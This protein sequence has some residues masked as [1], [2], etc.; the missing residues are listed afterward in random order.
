MKEH[1]RFYDFCETVFGFLYLHFK[2]EKITALTY[3]KPQHLTLM[4]TDTS[5]T[6]CTELREYLNLKRKNFTVTIYFEGATDFQKVVWNCLKTV[7]YGETRTYQWLAHEIGKPRASRA[8]GQALGRNPLPVIIPCH[9]IIRSDNLLGGYSGGIERKMQ[10]LELEQKGI[11]T[12]KK[13]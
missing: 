9:R 8:V 6:V 13:D 10:L 2:G 11:S 7:P 12:G 1:L 4:S 3:H 5:L